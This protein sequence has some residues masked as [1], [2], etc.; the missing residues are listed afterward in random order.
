VATRCAERLPGAASGLEHSSSPPAGGLPPGSRAA[1]TVAAMTALLCRV[2][3][4]A[5]AALVLAGASTALAAP[6]P[7]QNMPISLPSSCFAPSSPTA[8]ACED[9]SVADLDAAHS[10]LGLPAYSLPAGFD[11][12]PPVD[13]LLILSNDDRIDYQV[14]P[15][16]GLSSTLNSAAQ[17]GV[18][19]DTDPDPSALLPSDLVIEGWTGNWAG[20]FPNALLAYYAWMYD[21]GP[22]S[23]NI[24]CVVA[25][26]P[27]C[28]GHRQDVLAY[29][30]VGTVL[31]GA[32]AGTD[33]NGQ[34]GYAMTLVATAATDTS[35]TT[36]TY[37]WAQAQ[38]GGAGSGGSGSGS[39][40]SGSG[41]GSGSSPSGPAPPTPG[42][43]A[44][45]AAPPPS[46]S[47]G[48]PTPDSAPQTPDSS[49]TVLAPLAV[50]A[51]VSAAGHSVS[52]L[53]DSSA[54]ATGFQ[55]AL[56][57]DRH[58]EHAGGRRVRVRFRRCGAVK[59]YKHLR[60]G[61]YTFYARA[62]GLGGVHR[63]AVKRSFSIR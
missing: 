2:V 47:S 16:V 44:P 50:I 52:V 56:V 14:Q 21:D 4:V 35:W 6:N 1:G 33:P 10:S 28:W 3:A 9:A 54:P 19:D 41:S 36:L 8:A 40:G 32:A 58:S 49:A 29:T 63:A 31:M 22:G 27:A 55:C 37:T 60:R 24:D 20:G 15:I 12:L 39:G 18:S 62:L 13:Q 46:G 11:S 23:P 17:Q 48:A 38:S 51:G 5:A 34:P 53:L 59:I 25:S 61:K 7:S 45:G 43:G 26:D 57:R 30:G 42:S